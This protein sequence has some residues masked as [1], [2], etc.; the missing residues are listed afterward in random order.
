MLALARFA[1]NGHTE[2]SVAF[3]VLTQVCDA[4]SSLNP[5]GCADCIGRAHCTALWDRWIEKDQGNHVGRM[6][7]RVAAL[8]QIP[9]WRL[10][11]GALRSWMA[12]KAALPEANPLK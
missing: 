7:R 6:M 5:E 3:G 12:G 11:P 1:T 10:P 4:C 8:E 9:G 2:Y